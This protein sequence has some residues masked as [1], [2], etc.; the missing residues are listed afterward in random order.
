MG[1]I[2]YATRELSKELDKKSKEF[3]EF[4]MPAID[5]YEDVNDLVIEIDMPGF[6]KDEIVLRIVDGN[7]LS[8][9]AKK[10]KLEEPK[11]AV[12]QRQRPTQIDKRIM[13]PYSTKDGES[14]VATAKYADGVVALRI[15][16]PR[17]TIVPIT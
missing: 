15:P 12:Y 10:S 5:M 13:L 6:G 4:V 11:G 1:I 8:I 14:V 7:I 2:E 9:K 16:V 17:T 3:Y